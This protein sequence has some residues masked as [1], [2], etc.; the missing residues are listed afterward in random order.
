VTVNDG[1]VGVNSSFVL[2]VSAAANTPPTISNIVDQTINQDTATAA[3][4]VTIGDAETAAASLTL[5]GTSNNT[6]L[7]PNA[8]IVFGGSGG[9][10]TVTVTPAAGQFGTA[11]ITVTVSDGSLTAGD[12]FVL[13]VNSTGAPPPTYLFNEGFEGTGFQNTGWSV[14]GAANPDYTATPLDGAQSLNTNGSQYITRAFQFGN[15]FNMYFKVRWITWNDSH[16]VIVWDDPNWDSAAAL[17]ADNSRIWIS[18]GTQSVIGT[19]TIAAN[20]TYHVWV[21]W[22]KGTGTNGTM[23]LFMSTTGVKPPVPEATITDGTGAATA[24]MYMGPFG[25]GPNAIF[26]RI[27]IAADPIGSNP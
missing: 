2:T 26:D 4:A 13:T 27:L 12:T 10:R 9:N 19:T 7:V 5:T 20:T 17:W 24:N 21:E 1:T 23:K 22:T 14:S 3:I 16:N 11:T 18:H 8:N 15:A 25:A 6:A